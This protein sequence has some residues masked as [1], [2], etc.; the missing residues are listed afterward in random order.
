[1]LDLFD[2]VYRDNASTLYCGCQFEING[3]R[4]V[5][6]LKSCGLETLSES[7]SANQIH[8]EHIFPVSTYG[9]TLTCWQNG[10]RRG[11]DSDQSYQKFSTDLHNMAPVI[12]AINISRSDFDFGEVDEAGEIRSFGTCSLKIDRV[13]RVVEPAE[14][15][16]G[17][18]SR[19]LLYMSD[20]YQMEL[21]K[22]YRNLL[23]AWHKAD[24][25]DKWELERNRQIKQLQG[26]TNHWVE[27]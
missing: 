25:V 20:T 27:E 26:V 14:H 1:M 21:E 24:P 10:G 4:K 13:N 17:N 9:K 8:S 18:I 23:I 11:C 22:D 5:P 16:K 12:G 3:K 19:A 6:N 7:R 15:I 2:V